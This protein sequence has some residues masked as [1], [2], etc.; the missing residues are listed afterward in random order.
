MSNQKQRLDEQ[1]VALRLAKEF[2]DGMI[3]N[4]GGGLPTLAANLVPEGRE[5]LFH[6]E[7]GVLGYGRIATLEEA[8]WNLFNASSQPVTPSPGM[9]FFSQDES[10]A[11]IRGR[12]IDI[13][14]LGGLQVS[15]KGDLANWAR[16]HLDEYG[17][18]IHTWIRGG[19]FPP[20]IGGAMDLARG[21]K[22]IIVAMTHITKDGQPK[23]VRECTYEITARRC[24]SM[25]ITDIAVIEVTDQGLLLKEVAPGFTPD[26]VQDET[27][28]ELLIAPDLKEMEL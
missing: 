23:I 11:M 27:E 14:A 1:T 5:I 19:R 16:G 6:S 21:A 18:D 28:P 2:E 22:K 7:N 20:G 4:L 15:E 25:V 3:V 8:D 17:G 26:D 10:F 24:V 12:H 13:C 9:S